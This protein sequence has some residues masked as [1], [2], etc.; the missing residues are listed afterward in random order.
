[1]CFLLRGEFGINGYFI[2]VPTV[3]GANGVEKIIEFDLNEDERN[4]LKN[5]LEAVKK[6]VEDTNL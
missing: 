5:T 6:T 4:E 2:G 1:M 3:I